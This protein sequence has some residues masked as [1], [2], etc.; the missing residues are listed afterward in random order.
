MKTNSWDKY[1]Q[2]HYQPLGREWSSTDVMRYMKWYFSWIGY[3]EK[4]CPAMRRKARIFEIGSAV[5][6]VAKLLHDRGHDV[7][8]SDISPLMVKKAAELCHPVPF[9]FC[10][11]QKAIPVKETFDIVLGFEVLEHV[12]DVEKAIRNIKKALKKGG[13]F[14]GTSPYPYP[15]NFL[16]K[17][18]VNVKYPNEW[19]EFFKH[20]GFRTVKT[21][22]MSFLPYAWRLGKYINPVI[23]ISI[24]WPYFVSTTLIVAQAS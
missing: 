10:D 12:P 14:I 1:F 16:D 5:G 6:A 15:K 9:V 4:R 20:N 22:P 3:I 21:T 23:P 18:H 7:I 19:Q 24:G 8:G 17:T 13:Y 11:I 2:S